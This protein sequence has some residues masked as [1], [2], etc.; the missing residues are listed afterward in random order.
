MSKQVFYL[1]HDSAR[2]NAIKAI[3]E[4]PEGYRVVITPR[5]RTIDQNNLMW[6]C[7]NDLSKQVE[8]V[9]NGKKTKLAPEDWKDVASASL[10]QETRISQGFEGGVVLL[11]QRTSKMNIK[12][13]TDLIAVIHAFGDEQGVKWSP[14]SLGR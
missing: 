10:K 5:T 11:G 3:Q 1:A 6:S 4:A 14:T 9:I 13:M 7:L 8:W 2:A 12:E